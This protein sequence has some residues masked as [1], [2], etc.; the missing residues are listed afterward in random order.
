[1]EPSQELFEH[2]Q[3]NKFRRARTMTPEERW[4]ASMEYSELAVE[5]MKEGVRAQFPDASDESVLQIVR[6]RLT[7]VRRAGRRT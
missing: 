1:M 3:A 2:L 4:L 7:R 5:T 6:N